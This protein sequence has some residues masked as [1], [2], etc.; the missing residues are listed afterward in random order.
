MRGWP[1]PLVHLP[2]PPDWAISAFFVVVVVLV[3]I[4]GLVWVYCFVVA[5]RAAVREQDNQRGERALKVLDK[6][7]RRFP[8]RH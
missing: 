4:R 3:G 2:T 5:V 8:F 1:N 6:L 7:L